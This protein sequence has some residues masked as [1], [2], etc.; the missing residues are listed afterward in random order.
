MMWYM[1]IH[2]WPMNIGGKPSFSLIQNLPAF[3]PITFEM[4]V[5]FAS[6]LMVITY[7]IRCKLY[8]GSSQTS[9]DPRTTDDMFLMEIEAHGNEAEIIALIK[10]TGAIEVKEENID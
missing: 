5:F 8:P 7:L 1:M 3:I 2:D 4:T 9:P 10:K 6:H